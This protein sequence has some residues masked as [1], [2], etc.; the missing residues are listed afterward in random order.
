MKISEF[1]KEAKVKLVGKW[2]LAILINL[3]QLIITA[4]LTYVASKI[5]GILGAILALAFGII[6]IPLSYGLTASMLSLSRNE[7]VGVTDFISIGFKNL[8][9]AIFLSLSIFVRII[10][11]V[12]IL[13]IAIAFSVMSGVANA[14]GGSSSAGVSSIIGLVLAIASMI[15]LICKVLSY[16]LSTYVSIDNEDMKSGEAIARSC[17]LMK[18]YK[19]KFVGLVFSFI[20]WLFLCGFLAGLMEIVNET[21]GTIAIYGLSL[22]LTPYITFSEI[23]FYE[24]L[25]GKPEVTV[26]K[27]EDTVIE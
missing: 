14:I 6:S 21:L 22:L 26:E 9:R 18:G 8:K 3:T 1:K 11:P 17:E 27:V 20:G 24:Y 12:I 16:A 4:G 25:A 15:W 10:I 13:S 7:T 2:H 19:L 23:N 5:E